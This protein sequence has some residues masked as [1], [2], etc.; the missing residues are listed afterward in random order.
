MLSLI[1]SF[2]L[3]ATATAQLTTSFWAQLGVLGTDKIG[4]YGSVIDANATHTTYY[5]NFD[6]GTDYWGQ[7]FGYTNITMTVGPNY[8]RQAT[9]VDYPIVAETVAPNANAIILECER[10]APIDPNVNGTC[11]A[12]YGPNYVYF[13]ACDPPRTANRVQ[14]FSRTIS[15]IGRLSYSAGV[16]TIIRTFTITSDT[17]PPPEWCSDG[18]KAP[19]EGSI[20]TYPALASSFATFQVIVTAGEEK[21]SATQGASVSPS[22]VQP[23]ATG[24]NTAA[25]STSGSS[26]DVQTT[27][28]AVSLLSR[29]G[30][31][32]GLG[33][34]MA[35]FV[36]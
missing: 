36:V 17:A 35:V 20:T 4:Y 24:S 23:T 6:N 34:V 5:L 27:G 9:S 33:A 15:Y 31:I 16:E 1:A 18:Q 30:T 19:S 29:S 14:T 22:T 10:E 25:A 2:L 28:A 13:Q 8:Y 26:G 7:G 12:S 11:T 21:L 3:A 32:A